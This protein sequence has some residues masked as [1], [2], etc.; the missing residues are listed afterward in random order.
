METENNQLSLCGVIETEPIL[1]HE[2]FGEQFFCL[3]LRVPRLSAAG[4]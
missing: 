1:D 4:P 3:N 2:V